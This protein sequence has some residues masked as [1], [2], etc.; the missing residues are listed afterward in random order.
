MADFQIKVLAET[1]AAEENLKRLDTVA[2]S[3]TKE[4]KLSIDTSALSK[5]I[6]QLKNIDVGKFS[7]GLDDIQDNIEDA[8]NT[9]KQFYKVAK[10]A[11][12]PLGNQIRQYEQLAKGTMEVAKAAPQAAASLK[13]NAE[14][15]Q[16]LANSYNAASGG[17]MKLVENLA[18]VGFAMYGVQQAVGMV[19]GAFQGFFNETIGREIQLRETILKTQ[20]TLASTNKVF[21]NGKEITDPYQKIVNLTGS[22]EGRIDSIR[23]RSIE[24]AGVTSN[25]VIE[26]FGIVS[27][28]IGNIG[29]GL[30]EAEDLAIS[31]SAAL[32]T[33]GIP[34]YQARQEIGSILRG[35]IT[36]DSYLAKA[37]GITSQDVQKAKTQTGGVVAFIQKKLEAS[38]AGQ[39]IAA[40]S[41]TGVMSNI[42]DLQE[43]VNQEFGKGLLDPLIKGLT[44]VFNYLNNIRDTIFAIS[45]EAGAGLGKLFSTN[46]SSIFG[47][48][49]LFK[50]LGE[51]AAQGAQGF[52]TTVQRAFASL[53]SDIN[54]FIAPLRNIF[55]EL[56]KSAAVLLRGFSELG[57]G[58]IS[59]KLEEFKALLTVFSNLSEI[60]TVF[61]AGLAEVLKVYGQLLQLPP[62]QAFA[63]LR[64]E[65]E[66]LDRLGVTKI[67]QFGVVA[68]GLIKP[69]QSVVVFFR[70]LVARVS[71]SLSEIIG[72]VAAAVTKI[73]AMIE[74]MNNKLVAASTTASSVATS[75]ASAVRTKATAT[76]AGG[77]ATNAFTTAAADYG[78]NLTTQMNSA[79]ASPII[80][81]LQDKFAVLGSSLAGKAIPAVSALKSEV[82]GLNTSFSNAGP[83]I[84]SFYQK[85]QGLSTSARSTVSPAISNIK[86][87]V[88]SF[89]TSTVTSTGTQAFRTTP[90]SVPN[91][92]NVS[93][94]NIPP[95]STQVTSSYEAVKRT[96]KDIGVT[97]TGAVNPTESFKQGLETSGNVATNTAQKSQ[98]FIGS[99]RNLGTATQN[100]GQ[101]L[102]RGSVNMQ[103]F[104]KAATSGGAAAALA[105]TAMG[106]AVGTFIKA[107]LVMLAIQVTITALINLF[108]H[109]QRQQEA[110]ARSRKA[111]DALK[112]L[113]TK[114]K[115]LSESASEA[116]KA[117]KAY[118]ESLVSG[119]YSAVID[120]LN[121]IRE[122]IR[123]QEGPNIFE[124][125]GNS[126]K[127][128]AGELQKLAQQFG[129]LL[130]LLGGGAAGIG[131]ASFL[132]APFYKQDPN[133]KNKPGDNTVFGFDMR[134]I[135]DP[136]GR[137]SKDG[138]YMQ[139]KQKREAFLESRAGQFAPKNPD[140]TA[141]DDNVT[142]QANENRANLERQQQLEREFAERRRA[143]EEDLANFRKSQEDAVFERR[144]SLA[145][146]EID[147]FR[148]AGELRIAQMERANAKMV[149]GEQGASR[150]AME[151]LNTYIAEREKGE[152]DIEAQKKE[153]SLELINMEKTLADYRLEQEKRIA[154]IRR[155]ADQ[156]AFEIAKANAQIASSNATSAGSSGGDTAG[157]TAVSGTQAFDT[158]LRTGPAHT[159][160][161]SSDYHQDMAFGT[162]VSLKEQVA[163]VRQMAQAYDKIG[164][165]MELSNEGV[166]GD[167]FPV[168]GSE[169]EQTKWVTSARAAH[170][171]R[172]GGTGRDAID[173]YTPLKGTDRY[174]KSVEDTPML[175]PVIPGAEKQYFSGGA[176][177]AGVRLVK[178]GQKLFSLIH[179]R[180]DRALPQNGVLPASAAPAQT[181]AASSTRPGQSTANTNTLLGKEQFLIA[182]LIR[183]GFKDAQ[184]AAI[185]GS[186]MQ[187]STLNPSAREKG[188]AGLGLFQWTNPA[189]RDKVPQLTG[190]FQTDARNQ[191][192]FFEHELRTDEREA[193]SALRKATTLQE[194]G[195][196]MKKYERYGIAGNRYKYMEEYYNRIKSGK[197]QGAPAPAGAGSTGS[198]NIPLPE[199]GPTLDNPQHMRTI[200]DLEKKLMAGSQKLADL[201][202]SLTDL[203][204]SKN[205]D[206]IGKAF[207]DALPGKED[208]E[209]METQL[210]STM[211][212]IAQLG[213]T[214][215]EAFDP[216]AAK[217]VVEHTTNRMVLER[218]L[219]QTREHIAKL[220]NLSD[221]ERVKIND[222]LNNYAEKYNKDQARTLELKK[223]QLAV[224][225]GLAYIQE[226]QQ[227]TREMNEQTEIMRNTSQ[228]KFSGMRQEDMDYELDVAAIRRDHDK[229]FKDLLT[230]NPVASKVSETFTAPVAEPVDAGIFTTPLPKPVAPPAPVVPV[231]AG[232]AKPAANNIVP[233]STKPSTTATASAPPS[234]NPIS[235]LVDSAKASM[236]DAKAIALALSDTATNTLAPALSGTFASIAA[237]AL[238]LPE[239]FKAISAGFVESTNT[240][241]DASSGLSKTLNDETN[242]QIEARGRL[243]DAIKE[244]NDPIRN[245]I[246]QW[247]R[248][249]ADTEGMVA[250]LG[251]T[252]QSELSQAMSTSLIGLVNGTN[253]AKEA[254]S[255]MLQSIGKTMVDTA[256][257][258]LSKSL[259]SG[260][261]GDGA[262]GGGLLGSLFGLGGGGA[263]GG[264]FLS[265]LLGGLFGARA[266]GG[267]ADANR[268]LLI[269]ER[270][271]EI[272]VPDTGGQ[273]VPNHRSKAYAAMSRS[274]DDSAFPKTQKGGTSL[275]QQE[276]PFSANQKILDSIAAVSQKRNTEKSLANVGGTSEIKYSRVS[277]GD[278][279]FITED[280]ALRIAKQAELNGAKMGQQRTL[281][282]LRNNPST[283]RGVGI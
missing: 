72:K 251:A 181:A 60:A 19:R 100:L 82:Q 227:R 242:K 218:E 17:A 166:K 15:G 54:D 92:P 258:M 189:R 43:L 209:A 71:A 108:G 180:T 124:K 210:Y 96:V 229:K 95:V 204:N 178:N 13:Q 224:E 37:L 172:N 112:E 128:F 174:H 139:E 168:N 153:I 57:K 22:I 76:A 159:I 16:I 176:A 205:F 33:F 55:E 230:A 88:N 263:G 247:R 179:G 133:T 122:Q 113:N 152:L 105:I 77:T 248:E 183:R 47:G 69:F 249:L 98:G 94:P 4:R 212:T 5:S 199:Y 186:A 99:L 283:R 197:L 58:F 161:G 119:E 177:G 173:F 244:S 198:L 126:V 238:Q 35:Q 252:I 129:P 121:T 131:M 30:K 42:K 226:A 278:L 259:V 225:R 143:F 175:A 141:A 250:S 140:G 111:D 269:G 201:R 164:R 171:A 75:G 165:H 221:K 239:G 91:V 61:S 125:M 187:E 45:K 83:I 64:A 149:E 222:M 36:E 51:K 10:M 260:L 40:Q 254:F 134:N 97:F 114:Y 29:G 191:L 277:S 215:G 167:I 151:A 90:T 228:M 264:G 14:A 116:E 275:R 267:N 135:T 280:D 155:K 104:A 253:T 256:T 274:I 74:A 157:I 38:V 220:T 106:N 49:D 81:K 245:Q 78:K 86:E 1:K 109:Y 282:A 192:D 110:I 65:I 223:Q 214:A 107:N 123:E 2:T 44:N 9:I 28:Q 154:E 219:G 127:W 146:K 169:A 203:S 32:G 158:G 255:S 6:E 281:A 53:Q 150:A 66:I 213:E 31:F 202:A 216:E 118:L 206:A 7:K 257:Q 25:D 243:R 240:F 233:T 23:K 145:R 185:L 52:A 117:H 190:N 67:I 246:G 41:F 261:M 50:G 193:G 162:M 120:E 89:R 102:D 68:V 237:D 136:W 266:A 148:A 84:S 62:V 160:G 170:R 236:V 200:A 39:K 232:A 101:Q 262:A 87:T 207:E 184:I 217:L 11:P 85:L 144:Q 273:I 156:Y 48:S 137:H 27:S 93:V 276:D 268:P 34:L 182:E 147:I 12:T 70:T 18:K 80:T 211:Q 3:A 241:L 130:A 20:T 73:A 8:S 132:K 56:V 235:A 195:A 24:L 270:G 271:P 115:N 46:L 63:Q 103:K 272:F 79:L 231:A 265:S 208:F 279:P 59:I 26:V 21:K 194:A 142:T 188:G 196:A 234:T 138:W 163:L